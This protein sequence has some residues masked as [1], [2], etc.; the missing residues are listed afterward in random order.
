MAQIVSENA[1]DVEYQSVIIFAVNC[2][3][4]LSINLQS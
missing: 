3:I 1:V 2:I 4:H